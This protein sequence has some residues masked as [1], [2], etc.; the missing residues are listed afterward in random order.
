[1]NMRKIGLMI[2]LVSA[3][4]TTT[5][6][7][8]QDIKEQ[9]IKNDPPI[10]VLIGGKTYDFKDSKPFKVGETTMVPVRK[11]LEPLGAS[12]EYNDL[13]MDALIKVEGKQIIIHTG[14]GIEKNDGSNYVLVDGERKDMGA[15]ALLINKE[16]FVPVSF[17]ET[18]GGAV[19]WVSMGQTVN[20]SLPQNVNFNTNIYTRI[21]LNDGWKIPGNSGIKLSWGTKYIGEVNL[22][23]DLPHGQGTLY[24][25]KLNLLYS[26]QWKN[27]LPDGEGMISI[28][29]A[30]RVVLKGNF[31][32][33]VLIK[34]ALTRSDSTF[35]EGDFG[36]QRLNEG[37]LKLPDKLVFKGRFSEDQ[38]SAVGMIYNASGQVIYKGKVSFDGVLIINQFSYQKISG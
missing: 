8:A 31:E 29:E 34:G 36:Q 4:I 16:T 20:M 2:T 35:Y 33:G 18:I 22:T 14:S 23:N 6:C 24:S 9:L 3:L 37:K 32:S 1:M 10:K 5:A 12:L 11:I 19:E 25:F 26:G 27:G 38:K 15:P 30:D 7:S 21:F 13:T 28:S 17:V